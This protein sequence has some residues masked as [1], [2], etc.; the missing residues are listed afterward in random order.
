M[1][2]AL[3][4]AF[5]GDLRLAEVPVGFAVST[6]FCRDDGDA[7]SF[8]IA[9]DALHPNRF[10]IEDDGTTIPFLEASGVDFSTETRTD[11]LSQ[12]LSAYDVDLDETEMT[13]RTELLS[14]SEIPAAAMKFVSFML[15]VGDFLLLTRDKVTSTFKEDAMRM[16]HS[17]LDGRALVSENVPV[18]PA[19]GDNIPDMLIKAEGRRP[20]ALFFGTS[21]QR[22]YEAILLQMQ[23]LYEAREDVAVIALLES[24]RVLSRE[25]LRKATNRLEAIPTFRGDEIEA[26][27]RI[28]REALG[29]EL[30]TVH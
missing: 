13:I 7:V 23:A 3:C 25:V 8:Y 28:T 4:R 24:D 21:Q 2:E 30:G 20:I 5:C 18:S 14:E 9:R 16:I 6:A 29:A 15:R 12:L 10:R 19:M 1:K 22:V 26:V 17:K 27:H 11:A